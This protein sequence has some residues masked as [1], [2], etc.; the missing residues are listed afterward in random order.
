MRPSQIIERMPQDS[1]CEAVARIETIDRDSYR[2][3]LSSAAE[4]RK[5]RPLF[6]E[7]KPRP[8]RHR[9]VA[10]T[11]ARPANDD[12]AEQALQ[13]WLLGD[14][15]EMICGYLDALGIEH[16]GEGLLESVPE[17]PSE[18]ALRSVVDDLLG[19]YP[20]PVVVAYLRMFEAIDETDWPL[21]TELLETNDRLRFDAAEANG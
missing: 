4:R 9:W 20:A 8:E 6:L 13:L 3:L 2:G 16:D 19:N 12:L 21:L 10:S 11:L 1:V 7:K 17:Q 14:Y 15:K 18:E 5:L